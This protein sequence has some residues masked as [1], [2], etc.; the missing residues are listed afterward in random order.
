MSKCEFLL[1]KGVSRENSS[2]HSVRYDEEVNGFEVCMIRV[3]L[4]LLSGWNW[5]NIS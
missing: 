3:I 1:S 5:C 4:T 2:R